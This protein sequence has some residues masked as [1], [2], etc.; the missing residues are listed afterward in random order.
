MIQ[1]G[2]LDLTTFSNYARY[3]KLDTMAS[4]DHR[5]HHASKKPV[6]H[7]RMLSGVTLGPK[8]ELGR[9]DEFFQDRTDILLGK[10]ITEEEKVGIVETIKESATSP[11]AWI[12]RHFSSPR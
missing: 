2:E 4:M 3:Y 9:E 10:N 12:K 5:V 7:L 8:V 11:Y 1:E 6:Q